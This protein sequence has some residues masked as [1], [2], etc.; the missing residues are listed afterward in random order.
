MTCFLLHSHRLVVLKPVIHK[1]FEEH[2]GTYQGA[3]DVLEWEILGKFLEY[4]DIPRE[5]SLQ[6]EA[7]K[8]VTCGK[9]L[10][11]LWR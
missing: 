8:E 7:D 10:K 11:R 2:A 9:A 3:L 6:L 1:W 4:M 5:V